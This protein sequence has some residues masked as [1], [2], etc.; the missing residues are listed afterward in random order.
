MKY[1]IRVYNAYAT[2]TYKNCE[3][4]L[5]NYCCKTKKD[6]L[7]LLIT[8]T[9]LD[10]VMSYSFFHVWTLSC[11]VMFCHEVF[12]ICSYFLPIFLKYSIIQ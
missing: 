8:K 7:V 12:F 5:T 6:I 4:T 11:H 2:C 9:R 1:I 10:S 3:L